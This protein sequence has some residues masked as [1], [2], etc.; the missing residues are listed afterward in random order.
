MDDSKSF[1]DRFLDGIDLLLRCTVITAIHLVYFFMQIGLLGFGSEPDVQKR[2]Y[3]GVF[4]GYWRENETGREWIE[5]RKPW[6]IRQ[7]IPAERGNI[8]VCV[9]ILSIALLVVYAIFKA[10]SALRTS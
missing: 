7:Y 2:V 9:V 6:S 8:A 4:G 3:A 1:T 10:R 5:T